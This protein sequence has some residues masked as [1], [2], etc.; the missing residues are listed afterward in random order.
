MLSADQTS[1]RLLR[2]L[3]TSPEMSQRDLARELGI[4]L[5]K[6]NDCLQSLIRQSCVKVARFKN[7]RN[8]IAYSYSLTPLGLEEKA[9]LAAQFLQV[10]VREH[11][12]LGAQIEEIRR[13]AVRRAPR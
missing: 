2:L 5:G 11:E 4:S 9:T 8:K 12:M 6:L 13:D 1:Y 10:M 3:E 7:R